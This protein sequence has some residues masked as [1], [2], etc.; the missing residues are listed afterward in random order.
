MAFPEQG[1]RAVS[2]ADR[3]LPLPPRRYTT[4]QAAARLWTIRHLL[5]ERAIDPLAA[6]GALEHLARHDAASVRALATATLCD[7]ADDFVSRSA[8]A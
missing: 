2:D 3:P 5:R 6:H 8:L 7:I 1:G 4:A